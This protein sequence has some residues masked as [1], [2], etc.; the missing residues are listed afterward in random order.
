MLQILL[1]TRIEIG[2]QWFHILNN[3]GIHLVSKTP[4]V[5]MPE[6]SKFRNVLILI[7]ALVV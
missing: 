1:D 4:H 3:F 7:Q 2:I 6:Q 5:T